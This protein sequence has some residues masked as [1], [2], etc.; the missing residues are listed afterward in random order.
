MA[1]GITR[2][3]SRFTGS[4]TTSTKP[5]S[6]YLNMYKQAL[7]GL[8]TGGMTLEADLQAIEEQKK[9]TIAGGEQALV[10]SG[11]SGTTMMAGV[12]MQA[13]KI[14]GMQR[15]GAKGAAESKYLTTLASFANFAQSAQESQ[16]DREASLQRAAIAAQ[17]GI[18]AAQ[19]AHDPYAG[20]SQARDRYG[21]GDVSGGGGGNYSDQF[22]SLYG[23]GGE[24]P[25]A[26]SLFDGGDTGGTGGT[27]GSAATMSGGQYIDF[28]WSDAFDRS[29]EGVTGGLQ[30]RIDAAQP[31]LD[32]L[33]NEIGKLQKMIGDSSVKTEQQKALMPKLSELVQMRAKMYQQINLGYA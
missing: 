31:I 26:P 24:L 10:S 23:Q 1:L 18:M 4:Q 25:S 17:P 28:D 13:E 15:L 19:R 8:R 12:G 32:E 6:Q 21:M 16:L 9:Q 2:I 5:S 7:E 20:T 22:P 14:A 33:T 11:L 29:Q 30:A 3:G 27:G